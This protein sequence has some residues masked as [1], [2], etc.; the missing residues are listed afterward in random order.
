MGDSASAL[1]GFIFVRDKGFSECSTWPAQGWDVARQRE[2]M[3]RGA[4]GSLS[5]R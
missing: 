4:Q 1:A 2:M 3:G 5:G